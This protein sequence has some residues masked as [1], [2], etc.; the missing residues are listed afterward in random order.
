MEEVPSKSL[1]HLD[2]SLDVLANIIKKYE[3]VIKVIES[4]NFKNI[5]NLKSSVD[6]KTVQVLYECK[7]G[8]VIS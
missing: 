1:S 5:H 8:K 2:I 7:P 6:G 3:K 4:L